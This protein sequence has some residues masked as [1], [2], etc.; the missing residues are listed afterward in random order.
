MLLGGLQKFTLID[1]PGKIACTVF[2]IGCNFN[3]PFCHNPE[4]VDPELIKKQPKIPEKYFFEFLKKRKGDLEGVC[5]TGGEPTCQ[6]DLPEFIKKI[7]K[8]G[9]AVKLDTNGS[10]PEMVKKLIDKKLL[11]YIAVDVKGLPIPEIAE[12]IKNSGIDC[13]FRMTVVPKLHSKKNIL[14]IAKNLAP[15]KKFFLQQFRPNKTLDPNFAKE[16]SYSRKELEEIL[17]SIRQFF[18]ECG[19]RE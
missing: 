4:L 9:F 1:Y 12:M 7:K 13:E 11:D 19:I 8:L 3:C 5:I 17:E 6:K 16:K 18:D 2:T 10:N 15:A 14:E